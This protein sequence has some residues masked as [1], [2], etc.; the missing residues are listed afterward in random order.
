MNKYLEMG[1]YAVGCTATTE[2]LDFARKRVL[3]KLG[4]FSV[5]T[6]TDLTFKNALGCAI[7]MT[8]IFAMRR[9]AEKYLGWQSIALSLGSSA[10]IGL[11]YTALTQGR[12]N[13]DIPFMKQAI[14]ITGIAWLSMKIM[15]FAISQ[16]TKI[17]KPLD[18]Y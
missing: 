2:V 6:I 1:L 7:G 8:G 9:I 14:A 13:P 4:N 3:S 12:L 17:Q 11:S 16:L 18:D 15:D 10:M 5:I